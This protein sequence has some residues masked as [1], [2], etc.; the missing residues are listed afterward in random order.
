MGVKMV[1]YMI[2]AKDA[3]FI[4]VLNLKIKNSATNVLNPL[5]NILR[6][7][8]LILSLRQLEFFLIFL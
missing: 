8:N 7:L 3:K 5:V 4:F 6:G 1:N 2:I